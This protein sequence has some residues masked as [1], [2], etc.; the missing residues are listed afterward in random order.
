MKNYTF[1]QLF[2]Y[3][4]FIFLFSTACNQP[5]SKFEQKLNNNKN[6][7]AVLPGKADNYYS[8]VASEYELTGK[9]EVEMQPEEFNHLE[10]RNL[11]IFQRLTAIG[12]YLTTY[13]TDKFEGIDIN[14]DGTISDDEK[15]FHNEGYGGF[16]AMVRN[17]T[18]ET[19]EILQ[20]DVQ[21]IF[22]VEFTVDIAGP[23]GL[24]SILPTEWSDEHQGYKFGLSVPK[25]A[26]TDPLS[27]DSSPIH[28]FDPENYDGDIEVVEFIAKP[29]F[30]IQNSWPHYKEFMSD[31][32][33]SITMFYGHDYNVDRWDIQE[34]ESAF[35]DIQAFD[36]TAPVVNFEDL[37]H[38]SG[39]FTKII[40]QGNR[41]ITVEIR[42]FH[43][44]MFE[45]ERTLQHDLALDELSRRDVFF[46]NGHAGPYYGFYLD[47]LY[48]AA[49][50][51]H[52]FKEINMP[53]DRQQLFIAQGCQ[54]YSQYADILYTNT[55][56]DESNLDVITTVNYSY[57]QGTIDLLSNLIMSDYEG[58]H[59]AVSY[60]DII[61]NLNDDEINN[62]YKVFYGVMGID[63]NPQVHP[64]S[65][66]EN[67]GK[68]CEAENV[69]GDYLGNLCLDV[70]KGFA[71]CGVVTLAEQGCP[72]GTKYFQ[73]A[74]EDIIINSACFKN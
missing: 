10:T 26:I 42:I 56:K 37:K 69:C 1:L 71:E 22:K 72:S 8:S 58:N 6:L 25:G 52:E 46:Y 23:T 55:S 66:I 62:E 27:V 38:N 21:N 34:A 12:V 49:V 44:N 13:L 7:K 70:G 57:A 36:F 30:D 15:F 64:Y 5:V 24:L 32:V 61:N 3:F 29:H 43:S 4:L 59:M 17:H 65:N 50:D 47:E 74:E 53:S 60:Y 54:T 2:S 63:G 20:T 39:P 9:A 18:I 31:G 28:S 68:N 48:E 40:K 11:I 67:L 14:G 19:M 33:Y 73:I 16:N 51:Y 41:D 35:W 45:N